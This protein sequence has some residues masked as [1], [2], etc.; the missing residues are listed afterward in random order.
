MITRK[1]IA[2][3]ESEN[4]PQRIVNFVKFVLWKFPRTELNIA[5]DSVIL[6][7]PISTNYP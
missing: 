6:Q 7:S 5:K 3:F 1:E 2:S 4:I